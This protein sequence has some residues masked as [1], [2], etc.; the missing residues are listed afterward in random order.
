MLLSRL[1]NSVPTIGILC[2]CRSVI[3]ALEISDPEI[4]IL[5]GRA[6]LQ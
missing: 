5:R 6:E 3:C 1:E 4:P 2:C